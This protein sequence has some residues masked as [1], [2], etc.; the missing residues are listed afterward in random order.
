MA[1]F[2]VPKIIIPI[3]KIVNS[4]YI[5]I[6]FIQKMY[7]YST[8]FFEM[9]KFFLWG[10]GAVISFIDF[11]PGCN[12]ILENIIDIPVLLVIK[13]QG[14]LKNIQLIMKPISENIFAREERMYF[15]V[16]RNRVNIECIGP[17]Q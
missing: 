14:I 15:L 8:I 9:H 10:F 3:A 7:S 6:G 4:D 5:F 12:P 17:F 13:T 1:F 2:I 11:I 16:V